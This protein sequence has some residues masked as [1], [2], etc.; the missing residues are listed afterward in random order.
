LFKQICDQY[1]KLKKRNAFL[2]QYKKESSLSD[3][4]VLVEMNDSRQVVQEV[5][6]EYLAMEKP[7]YG[8]ANKDSMTDLRMEAL[9]V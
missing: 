6:D 1:D 9:R 7:T 3:S 4:E 5:I 8:Q 2:D